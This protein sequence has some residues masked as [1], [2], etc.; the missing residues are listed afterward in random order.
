MKDFEILSRDTVVA[1]W[2]DNELEV[3]KNDVA[4]IFKAC[5]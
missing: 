3:L 1:V 4:F 5:K 2:K